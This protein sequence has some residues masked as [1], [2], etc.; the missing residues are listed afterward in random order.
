MREGRENISS[1]ITKGCMRHVGG[2]F[3]IPQCLM[4]DIMKVEGLTDTIDTMT[5]TATRLKIRMTFV[6]YVRSLTNQHFSG[7]LNSEKCL[8]KK[9]TRPSSHSSKISA[10]SA[11]LSIEKMKHI[12]V[13]FVVFSRIRSSN[14]K[15]VG[16]RSITQCSTELLILLQTE[17]EEDQ[18]TEAEEEEEEEEDPSV[19]GNS[20]VNHANQESVV[21]RRP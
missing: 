16:Q 10:K 5:I 11:W 7:V 3:T 4:R 13:V 17:T 6:A 20:S 2:L 12:K 15:N 18:A 8:W 14:A 21:V 9:D 19:E 1:D